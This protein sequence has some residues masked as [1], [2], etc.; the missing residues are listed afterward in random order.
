MIAHA[1]LRG[2]LISVGYAAVDQMVPERKHRLKISRHASD[3][4]ALDYGSVGKKFSLVCDGWL[5][6][7]TVER[8]WT[9]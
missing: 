7:R 2:W 6:S 1:Q 8:G 5:I 4:C 3:G 9:R